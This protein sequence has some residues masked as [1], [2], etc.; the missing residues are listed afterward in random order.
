MEEGLDEVFGRVR[1]V[2]PGWSPSEL[3]LWGLKLVR[4]GLMLVRE[5]LMLVREGLNM[6]SVNGHTLSCC[7]S[8]WSMHLHSCTVFR[9]F[10]TCALQGLTSFTTF[11]ISVTTVTDITL[12]HTHTNTLTHTHTHTRRWLTPVSREVCS[13]GRLADLLHEEVGLVHEQDNGGLLEPRVADDGLKE[14]QTLPHSVLHYIL[15]QHLYIR[16]Q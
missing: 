13:D 16:T 2:V 1:I 12:T 15:H 14:S 9:L 4:E 6:E 3:E 5:G 7:F 10:D 11:N 8:H